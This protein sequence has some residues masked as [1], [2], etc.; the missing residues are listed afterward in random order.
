MQEVQETQKTSPTKLSQFEEE[1]NELLGR[2]QYKLLPYLDIK[3]GGIT[4]LVRVVDAIPPKKVTKKKKV[5]K[6][7]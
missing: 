5:K 7:K 4:P 3:A 1:L 2:Y 6:K